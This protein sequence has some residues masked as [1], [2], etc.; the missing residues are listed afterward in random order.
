MFNEL[1]PT[2]KYG[3]YLV[4]V[5]GIEPASEG[6][7]LAE[8]TCVSNPFYFRER[9]VRIGRSAHPLALRV[10]AEIPRRRFQPILLCDA[11]ARSRRKERRDVTA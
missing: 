5:A 7:Q 9:N 3:V 10:S 2:A 4:E 11:P 1:S 6:L 8:P